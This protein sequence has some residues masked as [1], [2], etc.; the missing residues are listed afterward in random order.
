MT[1][2]AD[3]LEVRGGL[4]CDPATGEPFT[5]PVEGRHPGGAMAWRGQLEQGRWHG[6]FERWFQD[7]SPHRVAHYDRG[8]PDGIQVLWDESGHKKWEFTLV[9]GRQEGVVTHWH[10]NGEKQSEGTYRQGKPHGTVTHWYE[11]GVKESEIAYVDGR[12]EGAWVQWYDNGQKESQGEVRD[13]RKV[14]TW[15]RWD[16]DGTEAKRVDNG[17]PGDA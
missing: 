1:R 12:R 16:R 10:P 6:R 4:W 15:I 9:D 5:G 17:S 7:G 3:T 13:G 14:G 11:S 8:T 2:D